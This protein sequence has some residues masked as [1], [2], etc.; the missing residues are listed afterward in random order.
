MKSSTSPVSGD[1]GVIDSFVDERLKWHNGFPTHQIEEGGRA[2]NR[3]NTKRL[4]EQNVLRAF[5][6][7]HDAECLLTPV[8]A[9]IEATIKTSFTLR[10]CEQ[11]DQA[12]IMVLVDENCWVKAGIEFT[13]GIPRLSCVVTNDGYSDWS[14][15]EWTDWDEAA[16]STSIR[17]RLSKILPGSEQ[18]PAVI[19]KQRDEAGTSVDSP[20]D[21]FGAHC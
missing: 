10:P 4:L 14:T 2:A 21:G 19:L 15:Q 13:D 1:S 16:R 17:V 8:A 18:G 20:A 3:T 5:T 6:C 7:Q 12:G 9:D 11:F